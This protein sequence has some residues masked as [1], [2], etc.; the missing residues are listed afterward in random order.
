MVAAM[1]SDFG[2]IGFTISEIVQFLDF[3]VLA[4]ICLLTPTFRWFWGHISP[5]WRHLSSY[6]K[7][8]LLAQKH[9]VLAVKRENRSS[10]TTCAQDL[11]KKYRTGQNSTRESKSHKSV[12]SHLSINQSIVD[13]YNDAIIHQQV[14]SQRCRRNGTR[15]AK[16]KKM[17]L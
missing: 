12:I 5:K 6:P 14:M 9:V 10:G 13:L 15:S 7:R 8:H 2:L 3:R 17:C 16:C 1:S 11:Q 4:W